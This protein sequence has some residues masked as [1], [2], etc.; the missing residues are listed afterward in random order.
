MKKNMGTSEH[1]I[2]TIIA[3]IIF[4]LLLNGAITGTLAVILC[5]FAVAFSET[6]EID[7]CPLSTS[8]ESLQRKLPLIRSANAYRC[9]P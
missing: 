5:I 2:R 9:D 1:M 4:M 3:V 7:W 8:R 6:D